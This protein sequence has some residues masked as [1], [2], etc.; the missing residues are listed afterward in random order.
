MKPG[1]FGQQ[2]TLT[3]Q[4]KAATFSAHARLQTAPLFAAL[5]A[6]QLPLESY[7]GQ[8]RAPAVI[9]G[10]LEQ[11]LAG[12]TGERGAA[13]WKA[14]MGK[15][16]L[17]QQDLRYFEPRAV[18]DLKEAVDA[19]LLTAESLRSL[20]VADP[21]ALL[22]AIY[23]LE[24]STLGAGVV[25]PMV[26]RAFLLTGDE[27]LAYLHSYGAAVHGHWAQ[28]QTRMKPPCAEA[29]SIPSES[30]EHD[31]RARWARGWR[32]LCRRKRPGDRG[33]TSLFFSPVSLP[34][35]AV[36]WS[37]TKANGGT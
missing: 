9:H 27:G 20:S 26:A 2:L 34:L 22:G 21:L 19:A 14:D 8:L 37:R 5:A 30:K 24:G 28:F 10:V 29:H 25:R 6:C 1:L 18:A 36:F 3:E 23:V 31:N 32:E 33:I 7:V 35:S 15:L 12:C 4:L 13:V 11:A 16:S 17:L